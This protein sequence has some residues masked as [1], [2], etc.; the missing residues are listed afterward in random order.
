M[1]TIKNFKYNIYYYKVYLFLLVILFFSFFPFHAFSC[2]GIM[3]TAKDGSI[4]QARTIEWGEYNLNSKLVVSPK[5]FIYTSTLNDGTKGLSW[6]NKYAFVGISVVD[7]AFIGEGTNEK[8]LNAGVFYFRGYGSLEQLSKANHKQALTDMD[9]VRWILSNF[10]SV[11]EM[12]EEF[13]KITLVPVML[14]ADGTPTPTG[15]W[16]VSDASGRNIVIEITDNGKVNIYENTVG[17]LTN[18]PTFPWQITNLSNYLNINPGTITSADFGNYI[19]NTFGTGNASFGLPGDISSPSRFVRIAFYKATLPSFKSGLEAVSASFHILNN[20]DIPI[21][22]E[23]AWGEERKHIP[24]IPSAT[25]WTA[26]SNLTSKH[27]YYKTMN[28]STIRKVD[29][30]QITKQHKNET[31]LPLDDGNFHFEEY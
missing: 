28:D 21:G 23:F 3:L 31:Y 25:Q 12:L 24:N 1:A 17:V 6:K 4:I 19:A 5:N 29:I 7:N 9:F 2:T 20:F 10:A 26:V 27:Y 22:I 16:R 14:Y 13:Q 11:D 30:I 18:S 8:G 15:H